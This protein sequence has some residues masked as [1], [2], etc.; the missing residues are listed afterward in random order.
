MTIKAIQTAYKGYH[1]RSRLEAR[2]AVFFDALG[3]KWLYENEGFELPCGGRYLPDFEISANGFDCFIEIKPTKPNKDE[4]N[5]AKLLAYGTGKPVYFLTDMPSLEPVYKDWL[6][7][8][9]YA[10]IPVNVKKEYPD[11]I[12]SMANWIKTIDLPE[13]IE[14]MGYDLSFRNVF[15][16]DAEYYFNKYGKEHPKHCPLGRFDDS[17]EHP[18]FVGSDSS[19][20]S[21]IEKARSARFEHGQK[22]A[23][24]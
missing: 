20:K 15:D 9:H 18:Y 10:F 13:W 23:T 4:I 17:V 11:S 12:S 22:G 14:N 16:C 8:E 3:I 7:F 5:K 2:Y 21:A 6:V 24:L 1:F 19:L